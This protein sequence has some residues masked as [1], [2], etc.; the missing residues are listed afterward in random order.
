[1]GS[2][3]PH[4]SP[5][6][7][8][9]ICKPAGPGWGL[10]NC[11][12]GVLSIL[13]GTEQ[14][15]RGAAL[16][17]NTTSPWRALLSSSWAKPALPHTPG[18]QRSLCD[19]L[20]PGKGLAPDPTPLGGGFSG[21]SLGKQLRLRLRSYRDFLGPNRVSRSYF[22]PQIPPFFPFTHASAEVLRSPDTCP[23]F[24]GSEMRA[25]VDSQAYSLPQPSH[26]LEELLGDKEPS[27]W[28]PGPAWEG[29]RGRLTGLGPAE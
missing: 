14:R 7:G 8:A 6:A 9:V 22:Y 16:G 1:M 2:L 3:Q 12:A 25:S 10:E 19:L 11:N 26:W 23:Y 15:Q 18:W 24:P 27:G 4:P 17:P 21:G 20:E 5:T 13:K 28:G 29:G